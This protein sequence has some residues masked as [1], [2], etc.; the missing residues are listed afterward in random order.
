[1]VRVA[2]VAPAIII[3]LLL[4]ATIDAHGLMTF[5]P[6]RTAFTPYF[7]PNDCPFCLNAGGTDRQSGGRTIQWEDV[8]PSKALHTPCGD[9]PGVARNMAGTFPTTPLTLDADGSFPVRFAIT[10][11]HW[12]IIKYRIF[13]N[14][15]DLESARGV[16][17]Q[18]ADGNGAGVFPPQSDGS[19]GNGMKALGQATS[20]DWL[21]GWGQLYESRFLWPEGFSCAPV[22]VIQMEWTTGHSCT[23]PG[24]PDS[25]AK[26]YG[27]QPAVPCTTPGNP[28]PEQFWNC[29][30]VVAS[31]G[32][33]RTITTQ[34]PVNTTQSPAV[35]PA[36]VALSDKGGSGATRQ[37]GFL[38]EWQQCGDQYNMPYM[39]V[40]CATGSCIKMTETFAKCTPPGKEEF[41]Q[42]GTLL[43]LVQP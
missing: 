28:F 14:S 3:T 43:Y 11:N 22:C 20:A 1:M 16:L 15:V 21:G 4:P 10:T 26:F 39:D 23:P 8:Y 27:G 9:P 17:L 2:L 24:V 37:P 25:S 30:D 32:K 33:T 41:A 7:G 18:R 31:G 19:D 38:G 6:M 29:A 36:V 42:G 40:A 35:T 34:P 12:G 13:A 5:P